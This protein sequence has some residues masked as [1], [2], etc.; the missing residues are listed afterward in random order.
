MCS[1]HVERNIAVTCKAQARAGAA[2]GHRRHSRVRF[3]RPRT[4]SPMGSMRVYGGRLHA[5]LICAMMDLKRRTPGLCDAFA[6][7]KCECVH[8]AVAC[9]TSSHG[10]DS[11]LIVQMVPNAVGR[12]TTR[13]RANGP[14]S[15]AEA[16][17]VRHCILYGIMPHGRLACVHQ[18]QSGNHDAQPAACFSLAAACLYR[19]PISTKRSASATGCAVT[20]GSAVMYGTCFRYLGADA[21]SAASSPG[22]RV[23]AVLTVLGR[24]A[25]AA[26]DAGISACSARTTRA[27]TDRARD[28]H[29]MV[30]ARADGCRSRTGQR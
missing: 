4:R 28:G 14:G 26:Q 16:R 3:P 12:C 19:A 24:D 30:N 9:L 29:S 27:Q 18:H 25:R 1:T 20:T 6:T 23:L 22:N 15:C 7:L 11:G 5:E 21:R 8:R 17:I 10:A 13:N 2:R